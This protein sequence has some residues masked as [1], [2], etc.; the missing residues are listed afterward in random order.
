MC[1]NN[2]T[3]HPYAVKVMNIDFIVGTGIENTGIV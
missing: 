2:S 1:N 3:V